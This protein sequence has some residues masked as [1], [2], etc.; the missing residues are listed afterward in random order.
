MTEDGHTLFFFNGFRRFA[1]TVEKE[2]TSRGLR[3]AAEVF[4][5][6][7]RDDRAVDQIFTQEIEEL[8]QRRA[9]EKTETKSGWGN[10]ASDLFRVGFGD[11]VFAERDEIQKDSVGSRDAM[12]GAD[13]VR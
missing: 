6:D 2:G 13:K 3:H 10:R 4:F 9:I 8:I 12:F 7:I 1:G 5:S 11:A